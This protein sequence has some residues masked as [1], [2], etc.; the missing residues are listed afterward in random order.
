[1]FAAGRLWFTLQKN[2]LVRVDLHELN[3]RLVKSLINGHLSQGRYS[4]GIEPRQHASQFYLLRIDIGGGVQVMRLPLL[5][6]NVS[7][8]SSIAGATV[9]DI[10]TQLAKA[11]A[12][13]DTIIIRKPGYYKAK[14]GIDNLTGVNDFVLERS[15]TWDGDTAAFWGDVNSIPRATNGVTYKFLN[16]TNGKYSD[17]QIFWSWNGIT[18]SL[19]EQSTLDMPSYDGRINFYLEAPNSRYYDFMEQTVTP[20]SWSGNTTRVDWFGFPIALRLVLNDG[21]EVIRGEDY[22]LFYQDRTALF[23]E[24]K[25]DVPEEF[26]HLAEIDA[27]YRI[28]CPGSGEFRNG[29]KYANYLTAYIDSCWAK[30]NITLGKP[31]TEQAFRGQPPINEHNYVVAMLN[32]H[33][34][35]LPESDWKNA[36]L[37]YMY[38][39]CNYYSRFWHEH[40]MHELAYGFSFD[41]YGDQGAYTS[42]PNPRCMI[43]AIGY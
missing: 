24:F 6:G 43:V 28:L 35:L 19:A 14:K 2:A 17:S 20:T 40:S 33:V 5:T 18:K 8:L 11:A 3:G 4:L 22:N 34:G 10:S 29:G 30:N 12:V 42:N 21:R 32:R 26:V 38:P 16:R 13:N 23:D 25:A 1:M 31:T 39:P 15:S 7:R 41:D 27:P 36:D 37:F 9:T